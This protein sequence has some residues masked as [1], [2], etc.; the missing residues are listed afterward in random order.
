MRMLNS[1]R[2]WPPPCTEELATALRSVPQFPGGKHNK[3]ADYTLVVAISELEEWLPALPDDRPT[4]A[5]RK[6]LAEDVAMAIESRGSQVRSR[7]PAADALV[8]ELDQLALASNSTM[9][10]PTAALTSLGELKEQL[11]K[12]RTVVAAFDDLA[13]SVEDDTSTRQASSLV[14]RC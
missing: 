7:T 5:D 11:A 9:L 6:S 12:P 4:T 1:A 10:N 3:D 8:S 13:T 14:S 2:G